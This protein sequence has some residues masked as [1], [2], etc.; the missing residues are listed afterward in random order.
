[1]IQREI[2]N[3]LALRLLDGTFSDGDTVV[4]DAAAEGLTFTRGADR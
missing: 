4:V 3:E 2:E 1:L